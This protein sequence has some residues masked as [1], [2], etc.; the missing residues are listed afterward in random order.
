M[1]NNDKKLLL[2]AHMS[3]EGGLHKAIETGNSLGCSA[4]QL[5]TKSNRQWAAKPLK[6]EEIELFYAAQ[7]KSIVDIVVAHA[8]YLINLASPNK[9][10]YE[11]SKKA[12]LSELERCNLL[13]IPYLV[14][15]PGSSVSLS[16]EEGLKQIIAG[17]NTVLN[18]YHGKTII[19][20]ETMAGQGSSLGRSFEELATIRNNIT[21][22]NKIGFCFDTCHAF[23]AGYNF[24]KKDL[25]K[26]MFEK[27]DK[28]LGITHIK[29]FHLNDSKKEFNCRVDRHEN[30]G[31]GMIG[32]EAFKLIM[33]DDR[34]S[35]IPKI[36]E[37]PKEQPEDD[38]KN[39][40]IL[41]SLID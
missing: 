40:N 18:D 8:T 15:H 5:F 37:T 24:S 30:I 3:I 14:L 11:N 32:L 28:I 23:A 12:L 39:L 36:L 26:E 25:Y 22:K 4:I 27:F 21:H 17:L 9:L 35:T 19:L 16:K 29:A 31:E 33:N 2:G 13:N 6:K 38:L 20:L 34:F 7:K 1:K 41:R 10:T